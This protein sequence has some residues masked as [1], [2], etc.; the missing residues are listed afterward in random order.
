MK[1]S[2][3][4][5]TASAFGSVMVSSV[6]ATPTFPIMD[7][8]I[9]S[10]QDRMEV[11]ED[12][13]SG[14]CYG[15][16][17]SIE[18][19]ERQ[20][21]NVLKDFS[22]QNNP[23][24]KKNVDL[25]VDASVINSVSMREIL[26]HLNAHAQGSIEAKE[27]IALLVSKHVKRVKAVIALEEA[28][29]SKNADKIKTAQQ[30]LAALEPIRAFVVGESGT[31][32]TFLLKLALKYVGLPFL[33]VS[34]DQ[35]VA[36]GY[37]GKTFDV[38]LS[39][40]TGMVNGR[41]GLVLLDEMDKLYTAKGSQLDMSEKAAHQM[42]TLIEGHTTTSG[43][44]T[45][46]LCF[47]GGGAFSRIE[48]HE[49]KPLT[50]DQII[51]DGGMGPELMGRLGRI[52]EIKKPTT[53]TYTDFL[54]NPKF[55]LQSQLR[56]LQ[57]DGLNIHVSQATVEELARRF[58]DT[59][60]KKNFRTAKTDIVTALGSLEKGL[61]MDDLLSRFKD[62]KLITLTEK[63]GKYSVTINHADFFLQEQKEESHADRVA[64]HLKAL[65]QDPEEVA[66]KQAQTM[67][68][69]KTNDKASSAL[70][71]HYWK[72]GEYSLLAGKGM[73]FVMSATGM[74]ALGGAA[75]WLKSRNINTLASSILTATA[76]IAKNFAPVLP[77]VVATTFTGV[78]LSVMLKKFR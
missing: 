19:L 71:G 72:T 33:S 22:Q 57:E 21:N 36:A 60:N 58:A 54:L 5:L 64:R 73:S 35:M 56:A 20:V 16:Q 27:E 34:A 61:L 38:E 26:D 24:V 65:D 2:K 37:Q 68:Q 66:K 47:M 46:D 42:L 43:L 18:H 51:K 40:L 11:I 48:R 49:G 41:F 75:K 4:L 45:Q 12:S 39:P 63:D 14:L 3:L 28:E 25:K 31:G 9:T 15:V 8:S 10:L 69:F 52:I 6:M 62:S 50:I 23:T 32:K 77:F 67:L 53:A 55:V 30:K 13:F 76:P 1:K 74:A 17:Q 78:M 7:S 59:K 44:P 70:M 29:H